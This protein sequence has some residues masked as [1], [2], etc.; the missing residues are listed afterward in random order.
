MR[1]LLDA[2]DLSPPHGCACCGGAIAQPVVPTIA[3][4]FFPGWG[5]CRSCWRLV[6][7]DRRKVL[8]GARLGFRLTPFLGE[9]VLL[10]RAWSTALSQALERRHGI[11]RAA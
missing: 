7:A 5:L 9:A 2:E 1:E 3:G 10:Q 6:G 8:R 4:P 11:G